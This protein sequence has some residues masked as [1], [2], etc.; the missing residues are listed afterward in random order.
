MKK[1]NTSN[2]EKIIHKLV[3]AERQR[4]AHIKLVWSFACARKA[5]SHA[6]EMRRMRYFG[7]I[8]PSGK[9]WNDDGLTPE[10]CA[11]LYDSNM[12]HKDDLGIASTI[13]R[14]WKKSWPHYN[15]ILTARGYAGVGVAYGNGKLYAVISM[16]WQP[17]HISNYLQ[18]GS[19]N[20]QTHKPKRT[21]RPYR[22]PGLF[23]RLRRFFNGL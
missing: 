10:C 13:V 14:I 16:T 23:S 5:K 19:H 11:M 15:A 21:K 18:H 22:K 20:R 8:S 7:H 2:I 3:N 12:R 9:D 17:E 4:R 1:I 6:N